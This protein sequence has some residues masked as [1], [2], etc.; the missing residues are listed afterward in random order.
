MRA[1]TIWLRRAT[2][3]TA[4]LPRLERLCV[5]LWEQLRRLCKRLAHG[6]A[7]L[8]VFERVFGH[9]RQ[10]L[11]LRLLG[12]NHQNTVEREPGPGEVG[13][14]PGEEREVGLGRAGLAL[15]PSVAALGVVLLPCFFLDLDD[16]AAL[17]RD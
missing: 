15:L 9:L 13:E 2:E 5:H 11:A 17:G 14:T 4:G 3:L 8:D 10:L 12:K 7:G 6:D 16:V 1:E